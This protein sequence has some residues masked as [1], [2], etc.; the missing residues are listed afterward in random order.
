MTCSL[1]SF[2]E[3]SDLFQLLDP[4]K[5]AGYYNEEYQRLV[6]TAVKMKGLWTNIFWY[7]TMAF[8]LLNMMLDV[9]LF[10]SKFKTPT[11]FYE[12]ESLTCCRNFKFWS[13]GAFSAISADNFCKNFQNSKQD[14]TQIIL[15]TW[16]FEGRIFWRQIHSRMVSCKLRKAQILEKQYER[17][18]VAK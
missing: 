11:C 1:R 6:H 8:N 14:H 12:S 7:R 17:R 13:T 4:G 2:D 5:W 3:W 18:K 10:P 16:K 15:A 9:S